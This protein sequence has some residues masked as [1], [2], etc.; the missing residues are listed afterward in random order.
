MIL[1]WDPRPSLLGGVVCSILHAYNHVM[2]IVVMMYNSLDNFERMNN[3]DKVKRKK[4]K[5]PVLLSI[6]V[7]YTVKHYTVK[8]PCFV[9]LF[10]P[11]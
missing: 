3:L 11:F 5:T 6:Y 7:Y 10:Y 2:C 1:I 4:A 8:H 9:Y